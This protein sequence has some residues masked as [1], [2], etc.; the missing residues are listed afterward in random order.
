MAKARI[1]IS[2]DGLGVT[3]FVDEG[4]FEEAKEKLTRFYQKLGAKVPII[5]LGETEQHRHDNV[6]HVH[7][8]EANHG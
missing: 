8:T 5:S 6:E 3:V 7:I 1:V 2:S 4:S